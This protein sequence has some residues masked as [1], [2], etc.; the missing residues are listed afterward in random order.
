MLADMVSKL[1][2]EQYPI[3]AR[4]EVAAS[5]YGFSRD[6]WAE[7]AELG[8]IGALF[9][10]DVGG[11]GGAG[12]DLAVVFE[13]LGKALV[14][15]PFLANL[16]AG[17]V[18]AD[19]GKHDQKSLLENVISG[20]TLLALAY[21]E[22]SG[23][24]DLAHVELT[25]NKS[26]DGYVLNGRK[27]V[28]ISGDSADQLVVVART[29]GSATDVDGISLFL[30]DANAEGVF[31]RGSP[32][33]D[34]Y[35]T[36][37]I[38]F[39]DVK[40]SASALIGKEGE[41][42]PVLQR[43]IGRGILAVSAEALGAMQV[44]TEMTLEYLKTRKQFGVI[45][46]KFQA[47]QHRMADCLIEIEQV[48]SAIINAAGH[49]D[50]EDKESQWHL[51]ALK[52]LIGRAGRLIGEEAIQMHGGIGMTFEYALPH[53]S[54]RLIMIDHLFGDE[55]HHLRAVMKLSAA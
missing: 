48:R 42:L 30:V 37:E 34:G 46:G 9:G 47:L 28:V 4:H 15:E 3:E 50:G 23:R 38:E 13:E 36:A 2:R 52:N 5:D 7:F 39:R 43:A 19:A 22:P 41:G 44:A 11:F 27:S 18:L 31:R 16:L 21:G 45:I 32:T 54:K 51:S 49:L 8:L 1:L 14:V 25:A 6:K 55:D 35:R 17:S 20:G 33:A 53:Y 26:G 29:S 10:E 12:F 24:Y 40:I